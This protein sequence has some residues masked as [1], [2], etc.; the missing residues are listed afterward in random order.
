MKRILVADDHVLMREGILQL[1]A[2]H[3]PWAQADSAA[4]Y[5][6]VLD[7]LQASL[8]GTADSAT[9]YALVLL[10]LRMPGMRGAE[11][12]AALVAA[13]APAPV[14]VCTGVEAPDLLYRLQA[15]GV[16]SVV[17]KTGHS[18]DL[19]QAITALGLGAPGNA[20]APLTAANPLGVASASAKP[21]SFSADVPATASGLLTQRQLDILRLLHLG[22]PNK[23]IARELNVALG[24]VKNHLY[25]LFARLQ[26]SSR[27]QA[28]AK[29]RDW[30]L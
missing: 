15:T 22:K 28:L 30:F 24:T 18:D 1:L 5:D 25:A 29:T 17:S 2:R 14:I 20:S 9:P 8:L 12:V 7:C 10:D 13:A 3:F 23:I 4:S 19:L 11:S 6:E 16:R 21:A 27:A 26:V